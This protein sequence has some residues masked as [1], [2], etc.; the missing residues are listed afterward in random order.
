MR[1]KKIYSEEIRRC[2]IC[3]K[4]SRMSNS[5]H[6]CK[7]TGKRIGKKYIHN[8]TTK[9]S[10]CEECGFVFANPVVPQKE[11]D[12]Y[13]NDMY[14]GFQS[15]EDYSIENRIA[16]IKRYMQSDERIIEI[17]GNEQGVFSEKLKSIYSDY[18]S[19]DVNE[20]ANNTARVMTQLARTDMLI[21]YCVLEHIVDIDLFLKKC[22]DL[23]VENGVF[24]IEVPD[25]TEYYR[26]ASSLTFNEHVNHFTPQTLTRLMNNYGFTLVEINKKY[27][28]RELTFVGVYR[29]SSVKDKNIEY[30]INK[31]FVLE[32]IDTMLQEE[33]SFI[34][35][36]EE[37]HHIYGKNNL[38]D[39]VF[40]CASGTLTT[41]IDE[42]QK[43]YG[44]FEGI[45]VDEDKCKKDYYVD[46]PVYVSK[47]VFLS[48]KGNAIKTII[49]CSERRVESIMK[50]IHEY[51]R[52]ELEI[53]Y[54][55][56]NKELKSW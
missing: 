11:W 35:I 8:I 55:D 4:N 52:D 56:E 5:E 16:L 20:N 15:H 24:L 9:I 28:S 50:T 17:G 51:G 27:A 22:T 43:R 34:H 45:V 2:P 29:K 31:S 6:L 44:V 38:K 54:I 46:L 37:I 30:K 13:Y 40:W 32:A 1:D 25:L 39:V 10:I 53:L 18:L 33:S 41:L 19:Y 23:L 36:V 48:E 47:D 12:K 42:Y 21:S 7:I 49:I 3:V 26:N 14:V